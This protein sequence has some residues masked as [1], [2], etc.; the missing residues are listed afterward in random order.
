MDHNVRQV[1]TLQRIT[2]GCNVNSLG[3]RFCSQPIRLHDFGITEFLWS[4]TLVHNP[5]QFCIRR[6]HNVYLHMRISYTREY[7]IRIL[8]EGGKERVTKTR[9]GTKKSHI[10]YKKLQKQQLNPSSHLNISITN[11][12][13]NDPSI[14]LNPPTHAYSSAYHPDHQSFIKPSLHLPPPPLHYESWLHFFL[15]LLC[16]NQCLSL[17]WSL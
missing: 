16:K 5:P 10:P 8:K 13:S 3:P 7:E 1:V 17:S 4:W 6:R 2:L 11:L 12:V 14:F 9:K 15:A